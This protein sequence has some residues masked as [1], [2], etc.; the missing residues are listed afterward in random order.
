MGDLQKLE[1]S[2][3]NQIIYD[4]YKEGITEDQLAEEYVLSVGTI[5]T[6]LRPF[7][8]QESENKK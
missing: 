4:K 5:K 2:K 7:K 6:I 8:K 1:T 3:R